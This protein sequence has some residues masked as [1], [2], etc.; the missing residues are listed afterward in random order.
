VDTPF[1]KKV[2][3]AMPKNALS[4]GALAGQILAAVNEGKTGTLDLG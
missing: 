1:W 2:P 4:A 3:F